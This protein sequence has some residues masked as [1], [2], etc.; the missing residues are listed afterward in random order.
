MTGRI[1]VFTQPFVPY[2]APEEV[3]VY[4]ARLPFPEAQAVF[5]STGP[6]GESRLGVCSW[7][8]TMLDPERGS[9]VVVQVDGKFD[10]WIGE[11][12]RVRLRGGRGEERAVYGYVYNA[13]DVSP[14]DLSLP[15]R[16]FAALAAPGLDRL[17]VF[18]E[19]MK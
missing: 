1:L 7:H 19:K 16:L 11:R 14:D 10:D 17:D 15:R 12:V 4:L 8:G 5:A 3:E 18:V 6:S 9:F 2:A 13:A